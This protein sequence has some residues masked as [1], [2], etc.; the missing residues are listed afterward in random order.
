[1]TRILGSF[2]L[3]IVIVS[4]CADRS[5]AV[6]DSRDAYLQQI[7]SQRV[8]QRKAF[9]VENATIDRVELQQAVRQAVETEPFSLSS[10]NILTSGEVTVHRH[11]MVT[12]HRIAEGEGIVFAVRKFLAFPSWPPPVTDS[13]VY[14]KLTIYLPFMMSTDRGEIDLAR[15][16]IYIFWSKGGSAWPGLVGC[17]G[18]GTGGQIRYERKPAS[19]IIVHLNVHIGLISKIWNKKCAPFTLE[20]RLTFDRKMMGELST[21]EGRTGKGIYD[22]SYD[23]DF[24]ESPKEDD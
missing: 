7:F 21:W 16:G 23:D 20:Q 14:E 12:G 2:C 4:G 10:L 24:Y 3:L 18:Y 8:M 15:D 17:F 11:F 1:M 6:P 22:E 19:K 9:Y 13:E 5:P